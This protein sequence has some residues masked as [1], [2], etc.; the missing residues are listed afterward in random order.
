MAVNIQW[1]KWLFKALRLS[2]HPII[3]TLRKVCICSVARNSEQGKYMIMGPQ[4][5]LPLNPGAN[6]GL[7]AAAT[8]AEAAA[9]PCAAAAY[10]NMLDR[11]DGTPAA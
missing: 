11:S 5:N 8:A 10:M 6:A 1:Q 3:V 9:A 2:C 7:T 4:K